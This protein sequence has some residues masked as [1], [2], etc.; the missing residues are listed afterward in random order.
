MSGV[1]FRRG[2]AESLDHGAK[3]KERCPLLTGSLLQATPFGQILRNEERSTMKREFYVYVERDEDG[4]YVGE[5][6]QLR[7]CYAQGRSLE[8]LMRNMSE[9]I[10]LCLDGTEEPDSLP[11][12]VG[13]QRV[14]LDDTSTRPQG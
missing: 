8:E 2:I 5:V 3:G 7:G 6:P 13:I 9:V 14:V 11:E 4:F 12:F 10:E 1:R